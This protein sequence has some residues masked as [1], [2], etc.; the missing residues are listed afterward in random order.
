VKH[1]TMRSLAMICVL[2]VLGA[3]LPLH[4]QPY[5]RAIYFD[6]KDVFDNRTEDSWLLSEIA[7]G[8]HVQTRPFVIDDELLFTE[9]DELDED[10]LLETERNLRRTGLFSNVAIT[11]QYVSSDSVDVYVL[12][13]DRFSL[14][15]AFLYGTGGGISNYGAKIEEVNL[16]GRGLQVLLSGLY[17]TENDIGW[18]GLVYAGQRRLFRSEYGLYGSLLANHVRTDQTLLIDKPFRTMSTPWAGRLSLWNSFGSDFNYLLP[19]QFQ[20]LPF[21]QRGASG[22]WSA[23]RGEGD[24]LF[25]TINGAVD[26]TRRVVE[27]SRQALDNTAR[28]LVSFG[29]IRQ[30]FHTDRFLN[31]YETEDVQTGAWGG[32]T[33]GRVFST[34]ATQEDFWYVSGR[35][36]QSDTLTRNLYLFGSVAGGS[37]FGRSGPRFTG[38]DVAGLAHLRLSANWVITSR[39]RSEVV[40]N[41][42]AFHQLV[43][44]NDAGI[45]G[46]TANALSGDN[47]IVANTEVRWFPQWTV[48]SFGISAAAFHD[49]GSVWNQGLE[50]SRTRWRH[51]AGLGLRIH[52][53]KASG[54]D[55]IFRIDAAF[56]FD[57][58]RWAGIIFTTDQLF[59]AFGQHRFRPAELVNTIIDRQ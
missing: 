28:I 4:A 26:H 45:R 49:V 16:F 22:W 2:Y 53:L 15:P 32:V 13:Q 25:F 27:G 11:V 58:M 17:R 47:R 23:A 44:D 3:S 46:Y 50:L 14:R 6:L 54:S 42:L 5:I 36:E 8:L 51:S 20:L 43:F 7:N 59:S 24:R 35:G 57:D 19:E 12:T 40:W 10:R 39:F 1:T 56:R 30:D 37:G 48:L 31:G 29:S 18:E 34:V 55:A 38:L 41:W 9:G 52:N 21:E 33:I